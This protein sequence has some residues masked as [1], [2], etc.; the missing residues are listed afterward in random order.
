[1]SRE[2]ARWAQARTFSTG[3]PK[4]GFSHNLS[5]LSIQGLGLELLVEIC[6]TRG[7]AIDDGATRKRKLLWNIL[8]ETY[9][10]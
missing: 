5:Y 6:Q 9:C 8:K 10:L 3:R 7:G 4:T 2:M 1:M